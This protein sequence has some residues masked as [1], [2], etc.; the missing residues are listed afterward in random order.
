MRNYEKKERKNA[1][2][3]DI[4]GRM[5]VNYKDTVLKLYSSFAHTFI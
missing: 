4:Q 1:K 5:T 2:A 3:C